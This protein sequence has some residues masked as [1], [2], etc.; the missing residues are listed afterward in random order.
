MG[1]I[2]LSDDL[3]QSAAATVAEAALPRLSVRYSHEPLAALLADARVLAVI[4]FGAAAPAGDGDARYRRIPLEPVA[5]PAPFE[6]WRGSGIVRRQRDGAVAWSEDGDYACAS[7]EV[8]EA[9]HGGL[10]ATAQHAYHLLADWLTRAS[11]PHVLRIW[12]Y[13]DAINDGDGDAERYRQF[14]SGR[15]R[16]M[17]GTFAAGFP[18]ATA[19][20]VRD[21]ARVLRVYWIAA[22]RAGRALENPRQVSAWRYPRQYGPNA[23]TFARAMRAPTERAQLYISGTAAIVGHASHHRDDFAAQ[24][25]ETLANFTSLLD[26][27]GCAPENRFGPGCTLKVYVRRAADAERAAAVLAAQLP[28]ATPQLILHGDICRR[29]LLIEIDGL[30]AL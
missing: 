3:A 1:D 28:P 22:R 10:A 8:D 26:A 7:V 9:A 13:L 11:M 14:C 17:D 27:A 23:P 29:E 21:G 5:A 15:A 2:S 19:I 30:Q 12:N 4:G 25:E 6:V 16:G 24:V 20:G 18:A